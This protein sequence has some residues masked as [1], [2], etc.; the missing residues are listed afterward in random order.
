MPGGTAPPSRYRDGPFINELEIRQIGMSRSGNHAL[1]NWIVR[2]AVGRVCFINCAEPRSNPFHTARPLDDGAVAEA[3][4]AGFDLSAERSGRLT[5]KDLLL[6]SH[7]DCFLGMLSRAGAFETNH[8]R[9]LGPSR[10]RV[11]LL[12]LRDPFNLFASRI[13][14]GTGSVAS[15]TAF[16]IWKQH[17]REF[18]ELRRHLRDDRVLVNYNRWVREEAYR[19]EVAE[20]LGLPFSDAG[21]LQVPAVG[22]GSSFDG[23]AFDG[24]ADG[25]PVLERWKWL[26]RN[27]RCLQG[28]DADVVDLARRIFGEVCEEPFYRMLEGLRN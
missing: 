26:Q 23:R 3:N 10:R 1:A 17:A 18:L 13:N 19:R 28:F 4:Y 14:G 9:W 24:N 8:D 12:L 27:P 6:F 2:Q 7:E 5:R 21:R 11:D 20:A 25:M 22:S 15:A 16:R